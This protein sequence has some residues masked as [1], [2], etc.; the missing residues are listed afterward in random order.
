[1]NDTTTTPAN[2]TLEITWPVEQ[3]ESLRHTVGFTQPVFSRRCHQFVSVN[4]VFRPYSSMTDMFGMCGNRLMEPRSLVRI[5][6]GELLR[7]VFFF[8]YT[9]RQIFKYVS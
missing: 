5:I 1:M 3:D 4:T 2:E 9:T 7:D 6:G 8:F